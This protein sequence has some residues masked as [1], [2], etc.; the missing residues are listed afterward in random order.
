MKKKIIISGNWKMN[1]TIQETET[2]LEEIKTLNLNKNI[3]IC[4]FIPYTNL[5][6]AIKYSNNM[7]I[8]AQNCHWEEFGTFTGEI[9]VRML[10]SLGIKNILIGHSERRKYFKENCEIINKKIHI[11]LKYDMNITLC[12]GE[13]L[14]ERNSKIERQ[15]ILSQLKKSFY[16]VSKDFISNFIIAY[17]P[18]WAIGT[19]ITAEPSQAEEMCKFIKKS[20]YELYKKSIRVIYGGSVNS[21][22]IENFLKQNNINGCLIGASS[23][24][25]ENFEKLINKCV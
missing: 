11:A 19:G 22:N 9:S 14:E 1:K 13:T 12:V 7:K 15:A 21:G 2:F 6:T 16:N 10:D 18:V 24:K 3:E 4:L 25:V 20:V 23:L 8:G 5:A 17:E